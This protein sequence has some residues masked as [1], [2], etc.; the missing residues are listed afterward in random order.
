M[1]KLIV[2]V[3]GLMA[4]TL[5]NAQGPDKKASQILEE[6]SQKTS[7]HK[8]IEARFNYVNINPE[9]EQGEPL[10]GHLVVKGNAYRL[11]I[12]GQT[13][14]CNGET[15]WTII[16]DAEEVQINAV[17]PDEDSMT[18]NKI[19]TSYNDNYKSRLVKEIKEKGKVIQI[20]DLTPIEGDNKSYDKL[21]LRLTKEQKDI[22]SFAFYDKRGNSFVYTVTDYL[23]NQPHE[24]AEFIFDASQFTD[25]EIV[26]MR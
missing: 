10:N 9:G 3:C 26:D 24:D 22:V 18:P 11:E 17:D 2:L 8:T 6:L 13:I 21:R 15:I 7:G 25:Y 16:P 23:A 14:I 4:F 12:P 19:F 5:M 1:K 20:I